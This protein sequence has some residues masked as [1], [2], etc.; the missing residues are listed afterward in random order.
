[1]HQCRGEIAAA[2]PDRCDQPPGNRGARRHEVARTG[3]PKAAEIETIACAQ[4]VHGERQ[5]HARDHRAA[6][7][8][9]AREKND[10]VHG[11]LVR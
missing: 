11:S 5:Q 4:H 2:K 1:M 8:Q 9:P 3:A 6:E 10:I 7:N